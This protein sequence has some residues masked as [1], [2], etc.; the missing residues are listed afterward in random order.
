MKSVVL[1][2]AGGVYQERSP[3]TGLGTNLDTFALMM[4]PQRQQQWFA[5]ETE[6][7]SITSP[8]EA[9]DIRSW[10]H[11]STRVMEMGWKKHCTQV[12]L[13]QERTRIYPVN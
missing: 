6:S 3:R 1:N 7:G 13:M 2:P 5:D 9:W 12:K 4:S 8:E 11:P 10:K